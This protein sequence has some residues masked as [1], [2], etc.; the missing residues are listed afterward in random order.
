[1]RFPCAS[2]LSLICLL[3]ISESYAETDSNTEIK[4]RDKNESPSEM[5]KS[6]L[7]DQWRQDY[8]YRYSAD[9]DE[10]LSIEMGQVVQKCVLYHMRTTK[11]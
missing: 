10:V 2:G 1:M 4:K 9:F 3:W 11:V 8:N 5:T 7:M 6:T